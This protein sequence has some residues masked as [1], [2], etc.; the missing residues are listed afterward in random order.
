MPPRQSTKS[1]PVAKGGKQT[2]LA[3][4]G[5]IKLQ[6]PKNRAA[7]RP[8]PGG[9][10]VIDLSREEE[11]PST[12]KSLCSHERT[13]TKPYRNTDK[14]S[15]L[16]IPSKDQAGDPS[17]AQVGE[18]NTL[19]R[20]Q[21]NI[22][23]VERDQLSHDYDV[24]WMED[25]PSPRALLMGS[26][27]DSFTQQPKDANREHGTNDKGLANVDL[28]E[29]AISSEQHESNDEEFGINDFDDDDLPDL[30]QDGPT[31]HDSSHLKA[32]TQGSTGHHEHIEL[33]SFESCNAGST[34]QEAFDPVVHTNFKSQSIPMVSSQGRLQRKRSC[35]VTESLPT[36]KKRWVESGADRWVPSR[37]QPGDQGPG[38]ELQERHGR[39]KGLNEIG[40]QLLAEYEGIIDFY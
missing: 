14:R 4:S 1:D 10:E 39:F 16:P 32:S 27:Y 6:P 25:F 20:S 11:A 9:I 5:T 36:P 19:S 33:E 17:S 22:P 8:I 13:A 35:S 26:S 12:N 2:T 30:P 37:P 23:I 3:P 38:V 18:P 28:P 34:V 29:T 40:L 7:Q 15:A 21:P 31:V 24:D